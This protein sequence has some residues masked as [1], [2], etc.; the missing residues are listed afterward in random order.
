MV[1]FITF[2][3]GFKVFLSG[4]FSAADFLSNYINVFAFIGLYAGW[5]LWTKSRYLYHPAT[6]ID[7]SEFADI[8]K[9]REERRTQ[10]SSSCR[11]RRQRLF[12][13]LC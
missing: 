2:F 5:K 6:K 13:W 9:E 4:N 11:S 3:S 1:S 8:R 12:L 10:N 7:L